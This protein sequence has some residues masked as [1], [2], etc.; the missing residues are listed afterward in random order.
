MVLQPWLG[1][2]DQI[3]FHDERAAHDSPTR[4]CLDFPMKSS[5]SGLLAVWLSATTAPDWPAISGSPASAGLKE[6]SSGIAIGA[7]C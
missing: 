3:P 4:G 6:N 7:V 2:S 5:L 1:V